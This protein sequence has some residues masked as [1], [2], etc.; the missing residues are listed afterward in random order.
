MADV[1]Y[2]ANSVEC[3]QIEQKMGHSLG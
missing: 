1:T 3:V 2:D